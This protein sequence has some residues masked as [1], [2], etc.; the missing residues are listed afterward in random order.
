MT[1]IQRATLFLLCLLASAVHAA[2]LDFVITQRNAGGN[3]YDSRNVAAVNSSIW[4]VNSSG[5]IVLSATIEQAQVTGLVTDLSNKQPLDADLTA[6]AALVTTS[7]GRSLLTS[8]DAPTL[9]TSLGLTPG[10][11]IQAYDPTLAAFAALSDDPGVDRLVMFDDSADGFAYV[12]IGSGLTLLG[13][14]LTATDTIGAPDTSTFITQTPDAAL[15]GEQALSTLATGLLKNTTSTGVLSIATAGTDYLA[16]AAI[17][18]T[19]QAYD[20]DLTSWAAKTAP[21]GTVVGTTD[22]QTLSNKTFVA[23][24]LGAASAT[25]IN[26]V[27]II[28]STGTLSIASGKQLAVNGTVTIN[29]TDGAVLSIG[30]GG[31]LGTA[32][33][34]AS[35]AYATAAEGDLASDAAAVSGVLKSNG[36]GVFSAAVSGTDY[37]APLTFGAGLTRSVNSVSVNTTQAITILSSLTTNGYVKTTGGTGTLGVSATVPWAD[38]ASTPTTLAGYGITN[39]QV[40]DSDLT[41]I[42]GLG[43]PGSDH[44]LFWDDSAGAYALLALGTNLS[45]AGTTL[46]ATGGSGGGAPTDAT[47]ITQTAHG[48]LS[49]EQALGSLSTG[50]LKNTTTTGVLSI[51]VAGTDYLAPAAIGV[52]VQA[53]SSALD[54]FSSNGSSYYLSRANHTGTQ[55]WST[56]TST[57]TTLSGYGITDAQDLDG[58]LTALAGVTV[59]ANQGLYATGADAFSTY[60][61]TAGGRALGGVAGTADTFPYFSASNTVT[62]G[63]ITTAGRALLDDPDAAAQRATLDLEVGIDVQQY[64]SVLDTFVSNGSAFY[65]ARANHTGTQAWS[66]LTSTPTT[67]SGYGITDAQG[68]DSDLTSIAALTTT[69]Y[70]RSL[71]TLADA[72]A[73]RT[74]G[75]LVIGTHVQAFD[76]GLQDIAALA[77]PN[78]DRL[79]FWDD[80]AGAYAYL[81]LGTN[82]SITGTTL[83]ASGGA[84]GGTLTTIALNG[85]GVGDADIVTLDFSSEFGV[86]ETPDTEVNITLGSAL[87]RDT[88]WDT[89]AEINAATTDSDFVISGG[90]LGTPSSGTLTNATGLPLTTGVTGNLPV[91][92][93]GSGT[94]AS[95][96]TFWRGDGTWDTPAGTPGGASG[97]VQFNSG[98]AFGADAG[99]TYAAGY[100]SL[101]QATTQAGQ[102]ELFDQTGASGSIFFHDQGSAFYSNL[103]PTALTANRAVSLPNASGTITLNSDAAALTNK[104]IDGDDNTLTDIS[105]T[106]SV[107]G[108]LPIANGGTGIAFTDPNA[109]RFLFWDDSAGAFAALTA[110]TNVTITGTTVNVGS[111][112]FGTA[113]Y[114]NTGTTSGTVPLLGLDGSLTVTGVVTSPAFIATEGGGYQATNSGFLV[115]WYPW[116]LTANRNQWFP[117]RDGTVAV[118]DSTSGLVDVSD[119][120]TGILGQSNGGTGASS[121][122]NLITLGTHTTGNYV[123]TVAGTSNEIAVSGSGSEDAAVTLALPNTL[124]LG[125]KTSFEVPNGASPSTNDFGEI[126]AKVDAWASGRGALQTFDGTAA[127]YV[128]AA[129]SSDTPSNGQVPKWNTGGTITWEADAGGTITGSDT[130][131]M[132][133]DGANT[134]AGEAGF[135]YN[136]TTDSATLV[137]DLTVATE[138]YDATGWNG[139]LTVPTKDAVRD[140]IESMSAGG[141]TYVTETLTT[142]SPN[143]TV[144]SLGLVVTGGATNTDFSLSPKGTGAFYLGAV[145]DSGTTGGNKRGSRAVDL[146][147]SR[148]GAT[149]VASGT[150]AFAAGVDNISSSSNTVTLGYFNT[151]SASEAVAMGYNNNAS[152]SRAFAIGSGNTASGTSAGAFGEA[153]TSSAYASMAFGYSAVSRHAGGLAWSGTLQGSAG[154]IQAVE[155]LVYANTTNA[156]Q[157]EMFGSW[158]LGERFT[159]ASDRSL[160]A[161]ITIQAQEA[162]AEDA[163]MYV[164]KVL[165]RNNGGTT[166]IVGS[167]ETIG[168]DVES[169]GASSWDVSITANDTNDALLIQ[170]TGEASTNIRW[171]ARISG[172]EIKY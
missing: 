139:D 76:Q 134:P 103:L 46:N 38:V 65:L 115:S 23:P 163:A 31:T 82:L 34:T 41:A 55:A 29:A 30:T 94:S 126:A 154:D 54:T 49:A 62:L 133:F 26:G 172:T 157:T 110:G 138:A 109:D 24:A 9:R 57:P 118:V 91:T 52:S 93:L 137:G 102:I 43:D 78:A 167:V 158:N 15:S 28:A 130:H 162:G 145:A 32:A 132:F 150:G 84:G 171:I 6:V 74:A 61:L 3:G 149:R 77:D 124:D 114:V 58:T 97:Q 18:V 2:P 71:L 151:A 21:S 129:L 122:A 80:S 111:G 143:G 8:A 159:L 107:K 16:P 53:H 87:T 170:V 51:A 11:D 13:N 10:T 83:N 73:L 112:S 67:L 69:S 12:V 160:A 60:S 100:I 113:A 121:L 14:T 119:E 89:A 86:A 90:A 47:Y 156:T 48:D 85:S 40:L 164:R 50:I 1:T 152:N 44:I 68:L 70:G 95:A 155:N 140:K 136:K 123:A 79:L 120:I 35:S 64:S 144:N 169:A 81:T 56:L 92:N 7:F 108:I 141:L 127:V 125:G 117:D 66:T 45:I 27:T 166:A 128:L 104:S 153:N 142:A 146:Q 148:S 106:A 20:A 39:G 131:V 63:S 165:I 96:T 4:T 135:V 116:T 22:T 168:T 42:A 37:E 75:E 99:F 88:E 161:T 59:A 98:G 33:Y 19:L 5:T 72:A 147:L 17:G 105:L 25:S 101:G 36:A